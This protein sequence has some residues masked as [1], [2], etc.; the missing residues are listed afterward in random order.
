MYTI[1]Y[2]K[3]LSDKLEAGEISP[4][5]CLTLLNRINRERLELKERCDALN[6]LEYIEHA[7]KRSEAFDKAPK[8]NDAYLQLKDAWRNCRILTNKNV[9]EAIKYTQAF[10]DGLIDE[11]KLDSLNIETDSMLEAMVNLEKLIK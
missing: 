11:S 4:S 6:T 5:I 1:D 3:D 10:E 8:Q 7:K 9:I 2:I